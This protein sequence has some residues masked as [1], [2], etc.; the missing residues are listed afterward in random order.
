MAASLAGANVTRQQAVHDAFLGLVAAQRQQLHLAATALDEV[1]LWAELAFEGSEHG[2]EVSTVDAHASLATSYHPLGREQ[3]TLL[4]DDLLDSSMTPAD[5]A[6]SS[7][8]SSD[9]SFEAPLLWPRCDDEHLLQHNLDSPLVDLIGPPAQGHRF[10]PDDTVELID[11]MENAAN[12]PGAEFAGVAM[13]MSTVPLSP[14][15]AS[16]PHPKEEEGVEQEQGEPGEPEEEQ[17]I[18]SSVEKWKAGKNL[19]VLLASLHE[20]LPPGSSWEPASLGELLAS[21]AVT[22]AWRKAVLVV[23][24]DKMPDRPLLAGAIFAALQAAWRDFQSE[25]CS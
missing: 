6:S 14:T 3:R 13:Q 2:S 1:G 9:G 23:H 19:R 21:T 22:K 18:I 15:T 8:F 16:G 24:P 20:V 11:M 7:A 25:R 10:V 5:S 12:L 17:D 4:V